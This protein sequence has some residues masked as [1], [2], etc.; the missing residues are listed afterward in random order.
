M[1]RPTGTYSK[2]SKFLYLLDLYGIKHK[3]NVKIDWADNMVKM[4][5]VYP[6]M[7]GD[8]L[9]ILS[10][11][12]AELVDYE[13]SINY[14]SR[15]K[16]LEMAV[17]F[18]ERIVKA[19]NVNKKEHQSLSVD[20]TG[21]EGIIEIRKGDMCELKVVRLNKNGKRPRIVAKRRKRK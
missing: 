6:S 21:G 3:D 11:N 14:A 8:I 5:F 13:L 9:N 4:Y 7:L 2:V 15:Q 1:L 16:P 20:I 19:T 12:F 18:I 10:H 17:L